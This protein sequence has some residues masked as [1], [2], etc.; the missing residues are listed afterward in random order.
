MHEALIETSNEHLLP[1]WK[2]NTHSW[3]I[4]QPLFS[5]S[6]EGFAIERNQSFKPL[7]TNCFFCSCHN[8]SIFIFLSHMLIF[9]FILYYFISFFVHWAKL[10][11][12]HLLI[13]CCFKKTSGN[14]MNELA[15][16]LFDFVY[17]SHSVHVH[18]VKQLLIVAII[19]WLHYRL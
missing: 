17:L 12:A 3:N 8:L 1:R 15:A 13:D 5:N 4:E 11:R 10:M 16:K 2:Q 19:D 14:I 7:G 6:K 9:Y 18:Y